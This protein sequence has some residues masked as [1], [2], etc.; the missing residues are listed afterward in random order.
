MKNQYALTESQ[1]ETLAAERNQSLA[2]MESFDGTYLRVLVT[3][4]Q[5]KLG[6]KRGRPNL[7]AQTAALELIAVPYYAAVLR[8]VTTADI[9]LDPSLEA[10]E[11]SRRTRERNRRAI[12]ARSAK[13]TLVAWMRAGGDLR[14]IDPATV[15]KAELRKAIAATEPDRE[16]VPA[17][18]RVLE[19]QRLILAAVA[20]EGPE[21]AREHLEAVIEALQQAIEELPPALPHA[22]SATIRTRVGV[23]SFRAP[24]R[25]HQRAA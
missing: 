3:G 1:I 14:A 15:T 23:P 22:E 6:A 25:L 2:A 5:A 13:S 21:E 17:S 16:G 19:A 24:A 4:V 11:V 9:A 7:E 18:H 10:A 12:F 8:G 20:R